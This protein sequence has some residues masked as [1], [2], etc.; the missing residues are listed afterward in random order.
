MLQA[1]HAAAAE[2]LTALQQGRS[3]V[4]YSCGEEQPMAGASVDVRDVAT[5]LASA[6][7]YCAEHLQ[8]ERVI[9]A[10]GDTSGHVITA[11]G[12][13]AMTSISPVGEF[14]LCCELEADSEAINGLQVVLKGGQI[15][16]ADFFEFVRLGDGRLD[17]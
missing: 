8:L 13:T 4:I 1:V 3:V 2:A 5:A 15:G 17:G 10:G 12:A 9:V 6:I 14:T 11:L 7:R 16:K